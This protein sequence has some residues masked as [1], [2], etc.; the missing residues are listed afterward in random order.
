MADG[1]FTNMVITSKTSEIATVEKAILDEAGSYDYPQRDLFGIRLALEEALANAIHHGNQ[2]DPT[3]QVR[4]QYQVTDQQITIQVSDEGGGFSPGSI[5]DPR[6]EENLARPHGRGVL[7]MQAYMNEVSFNA[8]GNT[9]TLIK[10]RGE[11][12]EQ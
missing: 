1:A 3:K 9:V 10:R 8:S 7:L 11:P 5:P 2:D 6:E 12:V 4:V